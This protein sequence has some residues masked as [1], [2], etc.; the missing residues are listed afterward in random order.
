MASQSTSPKVSEILSLSPS[1]PPLA[2]AQ[3]TSSIFIFILYSLHEE[4][5]DRLNILFK[6]TLLHA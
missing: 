3:K 2:S 1:L 4:Y 5:I 6:T